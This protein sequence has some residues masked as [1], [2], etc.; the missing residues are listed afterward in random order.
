MALAMMLTGLAQAQIAE[1]PTGSISMDPADWQVDRADVATFTSTSWQGR[2]NVLQLS[3]TPP[4]NPASFY[5][6][7]GYQQRVDVPAGDSFMRGDI[8]IDPTWTSGTSEDYVRTGLWGSVLPEDTVSGGSYVDSQSV[9]P[10]ISFTNE[11]GVGHL[12]V[13][14][15]TAND[16]TGWIS[17]DNTSSLLNYSSWNTFDMRVLPESNSIEY[18]LNGEKIYTWTAPTGADGNTADQLW[19]MYLNGR[20]NGVTS[21]DTYWSQLHAGT[22]VNDGDMINGSSGDILLLAGSTGTATVAADSTINGTVVVEN[23]A[24]STLAFEDGAQVATTADGAHGVSSTEGGSVTLNNGTVNTSGSA[25]HGLYAEG[26]GSTITTNDTNVAVTGN[27]SYGAYANLGGAIALNGGTVDT[28]GNSS[29]AVVAGQGGHVDVTN[30][31][32]S[33]SG[34]LS[35][36]LYADQ[37]LNSAPL[38][39]ADVSNPAS[40]T[41]TNV[42]IDTQGNWTFGAYARNGG[43]IDIDG[44]TI[45]TNGERAYG[46]IAGEGSQLTTSADITTNGY[47]GHGV[48]AGDTDTPEG[49]GGHVTLNGGT[50]TT[51]GDEAYGLHA[52]GNSDIDGTATVVT[53]GDLSF[54][55][56]A[57]SD[58][59]ITL[60]GTSIT[61]TGNGAIGV[62]ANNDAG[63]TGGSVTLTNG[64]VT[65][66]D[67]AL[68]ATDGGTITSNGTALSSTAD[69][70]NTIEMGVAQANAGGTVTV[71][72]GDLTGTGG[73]VN[74]LLALTGGTITASDASITMSGDRSRGAYAGADDSSASSITISDSSITTDGLLSHGLFAKRESGTAADTV[75]SISATNVTISTDGDGAN[76]V[77]ADVGGT[78]TIDGGTV[79]TA[80]T[81]GIGLHAQNG[82]DGMT[83]AGTLN[84]TNVAVTTTGDNAFGAYAEQGGYLIMNGG[85]ITTSGAG[86]HG[87]AVSGGNFPDTEAPLPTS[88]IEATGVTVTTS[89]ADAAGLAFA[90][91]GAIGL[92]NSTVTSAGTGALVNVDQGDA[93]IAL[94]GSTLTSGNGTAV[95]ISRS[96]DGG[97]RMVYAAF[98]D[99]SVVTGDIIDTG[100][101][102]GG[103]TQLMLD[104]SELRGTVRGID[105]ME[106]T[107]ATWSSTGDADV[108]Q[109]SLSGD[110]IFNTVADTAVDGTLTGDGT[111]TK[112]GT[113]TLTLSGDNSGY[114]GTTTID[115]GTLLLTGSYASNVTIDTDGTLQV[116]DGGTSGDLTGSTVNNGTLVFNRSDDYDYTGALSGDGSLVKQG[117]GLLL[118]SGDYS[119]TGQT[120]VE[121]GSIR[122]A[123]AL[124]PETDLVIDGGDFDLSD[125]SQ[126]VNSLSG[127]GGTVLLGTTGVLTVN[128]DVNTEFA[129]SIAGSGTFNK[130]GTGS[131]NLT[132]TSSFT[133]TA[134]VNGGRLAVNG[135][136]PGN[137]VVNDGG[138][139][140]GNGTVASI[141]ANSG[142]IVAPGNS[143]GTL[144]VTGDVAFT[145]GSIYQVE[146]D[147]AGNSDRINA[148]GAANITGGTV[149]VLA[150]VGDYAPFTR[151]TI[152]TADGGVNGAFDGAT[153]N[154]TF[155]APVLSEDANAVYLELLRNDLSF[156]G[157]AQT[158]NQAAAAA[159]AEALGVGN[160]L[161]QTISTLDAAGARNA[162]DQLSGEIHASSRTVMIE[163]SR[164]PR[165]AVLGR[166]SQGSEGSGAWLQGFGNWGSS[167]GDGNAARVDRDTKGLLL[168]FDAA[169]GGGWRLGLAGGY[170]STDVDIDA[171]ASNGKVKGAHVLGYAGGSFGAL[172]VKL[173]VG[174]AH[175]DIDTSRSLSFGGFTDSLKA[176][177]DGS[178]W[179]GFGELS[180]RVPVGGGAIEPF[181][182]LSVVRAHTEGFGE[183]G[184]AAALTG[185]SRSDTIETSTL[186]LRME[187]AVQGNFSVRAKGG[188][189]H[190]WGGI[191]P[192][193]DMAFA[194]GGD[195]FRISGAPLSRNTAVAQVEALWRFGPA[196]SFA[197]G[198]D[199]RLGN[200]GHDHA[201]KATLSIGF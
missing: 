95:D 184:G 147:A 194:G 190:A 172:R 54:G 179:Q 68:F 62:L 79:T 101:K 164:L 173:G 108:M 131:L 2:D 200:R 81:G 127:A 107:N 24:A 105:A 106:M 119:Y 52:Y 122:L 98:A 178:L 5:N 64:S 82:D 158:P 72:G 63:T 86:A 113:A 50:I 15:T 83:G 196:S 160:G 12:E 76:G 148:T 3:I 153:S 183:G 45:T 34:S 138:T 71:N 80:G 39:L 152:L 139:L 155:L 60:D 47:H 59:Q 198:Y 58:S 110:N 146:V 93:I 99:G 187:T 186:G 168:G 44:G 104:G 144:N 92:E 20:N 31:S 125:R 27:N 126:E 97:G 120:V 185:A 151:Y 181:A 128:Q 40:I 49:D 180:W 141:T 29:S 197:V 46:A 116:G 1:V 111:L 118:L 170:T 94:V 159:G 130:D 88:I 42:S 134:N 90:D 37:T 192:A 41:A 117:D 136:L 84:A 19:A 135:T 9:Y 124:D 38:L 18:Y 176:S 70:A 89:A 87:L 133:G 102:D 32:I 22:V 149:Q 28:S 6:W 73:R 171:R 13:W 55:A 30:T 66:N 182:A 103:S 4:A 75:A 189:Q 112:T 137:V 129:G 21:F 166:L 7:Q 121:G 67:R 85:S 132:G 191:D 161:Y 114:A 165:E 142:G 174:W 69:S 78:I 53:H 163:D 35:Y 77:Y 25:A 61:T 26:A 57:E 162:F 48:Q 150:G 115:A 188:W 36:G 14:D 100:V 167:D 56:F 140:G 143:I 175:V 145:P 123:A 201:A 65:A 177:Y 169:T 154:Y 16:D 195:S 23:S 11:G 51:N 17:L 43:T 8:W 157:V 10:I 96:G 74:G 91:G 199:G 33:T 156:A 109:L 193:T